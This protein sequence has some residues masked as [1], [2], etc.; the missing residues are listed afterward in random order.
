[1]CGVCGTFMICFTK[2]FIE[3]FYN[4]KCII[5]DGDINLR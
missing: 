4:V 3:L 2:I 5:G 1:M